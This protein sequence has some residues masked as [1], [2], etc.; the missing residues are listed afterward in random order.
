MIK[1]AIDGPAGAGK[2]TIAKLLAKRLNFLYIDSG[3]I[4]RALTWWALKKGVDFDDENA[5][6]KAGFDCPIEVRADKNKGIKIFID[7]KNVT[8]YIR[9][10]KVSKFV[11]LVARISPLRKRVVEILR[12]FKHPGGIVMDGRDIGT[13][14]YPDADY[15]FFL[16]ATPEERAK[17][18]VKELLERGETS[19]NFEDILADIKKRDKIDRERKDSPLKKAEGAILIDSTYMGIEEVV[20]FMF[21]KVKGENKRI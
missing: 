3:A 11:S 19:I 13:V 9:S 5:L 8:P 20:E 1:I 10:I 6:I 12:D 18:R 17:R 16:T 4:Y 15:K 14:V 2:S 7:G 21:R